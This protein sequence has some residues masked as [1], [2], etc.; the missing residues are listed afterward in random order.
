[1]PLARSCCV[2]VCVCVAFDFFFALLFSFLS[3]APQLFSSS[4]SYECVLLYSLLYLLCLTD[5]L[6]AVF[7]SCRSSCLSSL[8]LTPPPPSLRRL[9]LASLPDTGIEVWRIENMNPEIVDQKEHGKFYSGDCYIVLHTIQKS[10]ALEWDLFFWIG[11]DSTQ[12]EQGAV[13]YRAVE[14]DDML[15]GGPIQYREVQGHESDKFNSVFPSMQYL[16]GGVASAFNHVEPDSYEPRLFHI[17][18]K[19]HTTVHQVA[20]AGDSLNSG[21]VF[22]LDAGL[23]LYQWNGSGANKYEKAK[24]LDVVTNIRNERGARPVVHII[25]E[26]DEKND[27]DVAAASEAFFAALGGYPASIKSAEEGGSDDE[28]KSAAHPNRLYRVSDASGSME[29]TQVAEGALTRDMLDTN[30][31]FVLHAGGVVYVWVG[32]GATK[33]ERKKSMEYGTDFLKQNSLPDWTPIRRVPEKAEDG[34]FKGAF[35]QWDPPRTV[36]FSGGAPAPVEQKV[37]INV[38]A[39]LE[40]RAKIAS[41]MVDD[42]TGKIEVWRME[43]FDKVKVDEALHG[44]FYAGDSYIVLYTYEKR[45]K[46]HWI[47]YFWQG[48]DSSSDEKGSSALFAKQMDDELGGDPVQVRVVQNK[49]PDHFLALF[50]GRMVVHTGG[51]ASGFANVN[52]ADSYDTDGVSLFHVK[53]TNDVNTRAVQVPEVAASLNSGDCFVLLTPATMY[54]WQGQGANDSERATAHNIAKL[55]QGSRALVDVNEGE[56]PAEFW[57]PIG[58][59]GDYTKVKLLDDQQPREAR[60]FHVSNVTGVMKAEEICDFTQDDLI[61][62]DV[63]LLDTYTEVFVWVGTDAQKSEKDAAITTALDYVENANDGRDK[64]TPVLEVHPGVEPPMFTCHFLGWD[65]EKASDFA[66]PYAAKLAALKESGATDTGAAADD[67]KAAPAAAAPVA[68][69]RLTRNDVGFSSAVIS[70]DDLVARTFPAG[71]EVD[72]ANLQNY[73]GDDEFQTVFGMDKAAFAALPAWKKKAAKQKAKL[74]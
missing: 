61:N 69:K 42:A 66:D 56:E 33:D 74:F 14:L 27:A 8:L 47:I 54:V 48:R 39:M 60:M 34:T 22:V 65:P 52:D 55:L 44:Q 32:K 3:P 68:P 67:S 53:G 72:R 24:A 51:R 58:G 38:A 10:S 5:S 62:D 46:P 41:D 70:Y 63:M 6:L 40:Q 20:M 30:D 57:E 1:V 7:L 43:D 25:P 35:T 64:D 29:M 50:K 4:V 21:D 15:G 2:C 11:R 71:V 36:D 12:D 18:G 49:E 28:V 73:L 23:N 17:K 19:R 45:N 31:C 26:G 13:A 16:D 59:Q 37:D 9:R